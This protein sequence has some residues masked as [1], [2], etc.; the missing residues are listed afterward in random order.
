MIREEFQS[1]SGRDKVPDSNKVTVKTLDAYVCERVK[2]LT[3]CKQSPATAY[4][5]NVRDFPVGIVGA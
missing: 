2:Q 5:P 1:L 3:A 4:P